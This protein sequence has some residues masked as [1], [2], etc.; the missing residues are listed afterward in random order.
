MNRYNGTFVVFLYICDFIRDILTLLVELAITTFLLVTI[1]RFYKN[2]KKVLKCDD[3]SDPII[4]RRTDMNNSKLTLY[5][6]FFSSTTHICAFLSETFLDY[7]RHYIYVVVMF[8]FHFFFLTK[9]SLNFFIFLRLNKKFKRNFISLLPKRF[10]TRRKKVSPV[11][12]HATCPINSLNVAADPLDLN[13]LRN[14]KW[15]QV[16]YESGAMVEETHL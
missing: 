15:V 8:I 16:L 12:N 5:I 7:S 10:R 11:K 1:V 13:S 4:F 6:C 14:E 9:Y 2:K 3:Q